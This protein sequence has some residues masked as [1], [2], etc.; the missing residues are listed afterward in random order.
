MIHLTQTSNW[1]STMDAKRFAHR[2][3]EIARPPRTRKFA[4]WF[5]SIMVAIGVFF[6]LVAPPLLR[7]KLASLLTDKLHRQVS[8]EQI[9]INPYALTATI[10]GFMVKEPQ[11]PATAISFDELHLNL[12]LWSL[13]RLAAVVKELRLVRPYINLVRNEDRT[14]NY[15]DLIKEFTS[16][17]PRPPGPP[18]R[19]ALNNIEIVDGRIDFDDR[20]EKTKH[21]ISSIRIGVPFISSLPSQV[22][23]RVQPSFSATINGSPFAIGAD[24]K[25]FKESHESTIHLNFD[26]LQVSKYLEYSPVELNFKVPAGTIDG[27]LTASFRSA[28]GK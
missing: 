4:I 22:D 10:R 9:R 12:E 21:T 28:E 27:S 26:K 1:I 18:P 15:Q 6:G 8:I 17:P 16:G 2:A 19:F 24:T 13:F 14:Y 20:P 3:T 23:I 7:G 5:V 11:G 25:P